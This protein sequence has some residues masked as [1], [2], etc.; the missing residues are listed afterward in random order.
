M[1]KLLEKSKRLFMFLSFLRLEVFVLFYMFTY[2]I[3]RVPLE[4][5]VQDKICLQYYNLSS[6]Y[7]TKLPELSRDNDIGGFKSKILKEAT[8]FNFY[9]TIIATCPSVIWS[10]FIGSWM[11]KYVHA[12]KIL[13]I[14]SAIGAF[15][16]VVLIGLNAFMFNWGI[17]F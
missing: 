17:E 16:E 10:L 2:Y 5:L 12:R 14:V 7:C 13:L 1:G 9:H 15:S 11:D 3:K 8:Q 6:D 4:Q